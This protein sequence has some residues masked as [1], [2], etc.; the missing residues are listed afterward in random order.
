VEETKKVEEKLQRIKEKV[1]LTE[2]KTMQN[3]VHIFWH[4]ASFNVSP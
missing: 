1:V 3:E 4:I 2:E